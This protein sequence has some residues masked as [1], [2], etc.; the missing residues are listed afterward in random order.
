MRKKLKQLK[1]GEI[2]A[3]AFNDAVDA[4]FD[5]LV[6]NGVYYISKGQIKAANKQYSN[7]KNDYEMTFDSD[8][9]VTVVCLLCLLLW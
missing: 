9:S 5:T 1:Q 6:E 3:T 4:H 7:V 8:T 2:R